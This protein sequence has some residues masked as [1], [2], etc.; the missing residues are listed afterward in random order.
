MMGTQCQILK[1]PALTVI[2][3]MRDS[4]SVSFDPLFEHVA[5]AVLR[6]QLPAALLQ[7]PVAIRARFQK[8]NGL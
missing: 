3:Y 7:C 4:M 1:G 5:A 6:L 2:D 8:K